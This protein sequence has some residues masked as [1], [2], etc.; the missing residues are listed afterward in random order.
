M[1]EFPN[2]TLNYGENM[3]D[4][5]FQGKIDGTVWK[6]IDDLKVFKV[7]DLEEFQKTFSAYQKPQVTHHSLSPQIY[8][9]ETRS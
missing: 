1:G 2:L 7:L 9:E 6:E 5:L 4:C 3:Y 8:T